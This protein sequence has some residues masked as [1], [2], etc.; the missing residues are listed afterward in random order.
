M[1]NELLCNWDN[2]YRF[3]NFHFLEKPSDI[4]FKNCQTTP[5]FAIFCLVRRLEVCQIG[6]PTEFFK[7][8]L[9]KFTAKVFQNSLN[10]L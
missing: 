10:F 3:V 7:V 4:K 9:S 1:M 2:L 6:S 5:N 8:S